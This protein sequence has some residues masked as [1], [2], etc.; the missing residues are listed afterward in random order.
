MNI[1]LKAVFWSCVVLIGYSYLLY[2]MILFL[3]SSLQKAER[4]QDR[5]T[6][7][8][9]FQWPK[10]TMLVAAHNEEGII[11]EK[12][13]NCLAIDYPDK[14]F[15]VVI[16]SDGSND[17]TNAI[18]QSCKNP[19]IQLIAYPERQ[20]KIGTLNATLPTLTDQI[21]VMSDANTM[22]SPDAVRK[23]ARHF[24]DERVGCVCGE[25]ILESPEGGGSG[26]GLYWKYETLLKRMESKC[27]FLLGATGGIFAIRKS[28]FQPL[29]PGTIIEDFVTGMKVLAQGFKVCY[30]PEARATE[31]ME[32]TMRDEMRRKSRIGAGGFQAIGLTAEMLNPG[33][34]LPAIGYWSHKIIRWFVPFLMVGALAANV[35]LVT[36]T[37]YVLL[38]ALQLLAY[39]IGIQGLLARRRGNRLVQ[40][41]HYF[42]LMNLALFIGF[43]RYIRGT[44]RVTW[45][46]ARS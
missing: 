36:E 18:V 39:V 7:A 23:L 30:E 9:R 40:P 28:L 27:G 44:Q 1:L 2:P 26:E 33:R 24:A 16:A 25:L 42:F 22:Y 14:N 41:I 21:V 19:R 32:P 31:F 12:I 35:G 15:H 13:R 3:L 38:L 6:S 20:G 5:R 8:D 46:R 29:P 37:G 4:R 45:E 11:K 34:G 10:V 17:R 43:F